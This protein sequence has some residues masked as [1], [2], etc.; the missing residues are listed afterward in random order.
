MLVL[1]Y[2][3]SLHLQL[4]RS[5]STL[6]FSVLRHDSLVCVRIASASWNQTSEVRRRWRRNGFVTSPRGTDIPLLFFPICHHF[7]SCFLLFSLRSSTRSHTSHSLRLYSL[8]H[9]PTTHALSKRRSHIFTY[10]HIFYY[11]SSPIV[12]RLVLPSVWGHHSERDTFPGLLDRAGRGLVL[13]QL[14]NKLDK[15]TSGQELGSPL[16][17]W[18]GHSHS[19]MKWV[20]R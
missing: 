11:P 13:I 5:I 2:R 8:T 18:L 16:T 3:A 7:S 12:T 1:S 4:Q 17:L 15:W 10:S 9:L 6:L 20:I 14:T 19:A